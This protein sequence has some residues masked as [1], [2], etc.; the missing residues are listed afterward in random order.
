M[1]GLGFS[2]A[3]HAIAAAAAAFVPLLWPDVLPEQP[4]DYVHV[5][6]YDPPPPPPLPLPKGNPML[7]RPAEHTP[8]PPRRATPAPEA[9]EKAADATVLP[10]LVMPPGFAPPERAAE[11]WGSETGS[12][13]GVPEGMEGGIAGG[14]VGGVP[15]GVIGGV[16]GGRLGGLLPVRDYDEPPRLIRST[17]PRYPQEAFVKKVQGT[18]LLE[19]LIDAQGRVAHARVLESIP[20]LDAAALASVGDWLFQPAVKHGRPVPTL[21]RAPIRFVI[22]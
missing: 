10:A 5:L 22:Y 11:R 8:A 1:G 15:G 18:V 3:A 4:A 14:Q 9:S 6:M 17:R 13:A 12:D 7:P 20:M 2:L 19:I 16:V 21:A